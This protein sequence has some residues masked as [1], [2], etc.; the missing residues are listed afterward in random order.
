MPTRNSYVPAGS[1]VVDR[2][3]FY[4][5][6]S[7]EGRLFVDYMAY[8]WLAEFK[9]VSNAPLGEQGARE[10]AIALLQHCWDG[11]M[12]EMLPVLVAPLASPQMAAEVLGNLGGKEIER[13]V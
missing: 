13:M 4:E 1:S 10:L 3:L 7:D 9:Q 8:K 6:L 2:Q 5:Q 11:Q 12:P